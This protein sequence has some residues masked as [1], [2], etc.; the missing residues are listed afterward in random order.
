MLK[1]MIGSIV[2]KNMAKKLKNSTIQ[3]DDIKDVLR[4]I[5]ITLLDADVNFT[6]VKNFINNVKAKSIGVIRILPANV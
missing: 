4:E 1:S 5:R 3:E 2:T 6:V